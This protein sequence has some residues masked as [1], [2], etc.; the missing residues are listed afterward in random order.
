MKCHI[1]EDYR[2]L[3]NSEFLVQSQINPYVSYGKV[4]GSWEDLSAGASVASSQTDSS[5]T[6]LM[7]E[8][9]KVT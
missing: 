2:R 4:N 7:N 1:S 5:V 6:G 9:H 8:A 3:L